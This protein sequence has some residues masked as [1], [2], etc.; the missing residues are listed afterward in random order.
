MNAEQRAQ[1]LIKEWLATNPIDLTKVK[2]VLE[3]NLETAFYAV[4]N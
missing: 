4:Q 2:E 1:Q 3:S